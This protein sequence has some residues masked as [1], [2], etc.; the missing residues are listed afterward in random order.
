MF[1]IDANN[2]YNRG[3]L[4]LEMAIICYFYMLYTFVNIIRNRSTIRSDE[5]YPML[6]FPIPPIIGGVIQA[7]VYGLSMIWI[8][9]SFSLLIIFV[10][11]QGKDL[12]L[13]YLTG[14]FNR[15]Q[16]DNYLSQRLKNRRSGKVLGGIMMDIDDFKVI[17]DVYGHQVGDQALEI[18]GNILR[19]SF[20]KN[21]FIS[22]YGGDE[23][24][25]IIDSKNQG[26]LN[27][28]V[29][30]VKDNVERFNQ[31]ELAPYELRLSFGYDVYDMNSDMTAD[32]F[33]KHIDEL[34]YEDKMSKTEK[35]KIR[36][37][38]VSLDLPADS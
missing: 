14:L 25:V 2:G 15:R 13:D 16:L 21:D 19:N 12:R 30:R 24:T 36:I 7:L 3:A 26:D 37:M 22:R 17:N 1:Y 38:G 29:K 11:I 18:M 10:N 34:M 8:A 9:M 5:F 31:Q 23:F 4:Y 33:L 20:R 27:Q 6:A 28:T 32:Q 35:I